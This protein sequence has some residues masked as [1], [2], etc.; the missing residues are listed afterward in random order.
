MFERLE[1]FRL[2][3]GMAEHAR[4][5][6][7]VAAQNIAQADTPGYRALEVADFASSHGG[8]SRGASGADPFAMRATRPSHLG[9]HLGGE[10]K[11]AARVIEAQGP[12][13]PDGNTVSIEAEMANAARAKGDHDRALAIYRNGLSVLRASLGKR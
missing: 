9:G 7:T 11:V 13:S 4:Q 1:M 6:Q 2:A 12:A 5:R 3:G 10:T 8:G